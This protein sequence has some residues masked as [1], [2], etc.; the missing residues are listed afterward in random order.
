MSWGGMADGR[1]VKLVEHAE[2]IIIT[3]SCIRN[4]IHTYVQEIARALSLERC[5]PQGR[6][7]LLALCSQ[8]L[9]DVNSDVKSKLRTRQE[10]L[11]R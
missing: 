4:D 6:L 3:A 1:Y 9:V 7:V 2:A 10:Q 5:A 8:L 11:T